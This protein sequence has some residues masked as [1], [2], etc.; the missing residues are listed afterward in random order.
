MAG[1]V[2]GINL[3]IRSRDQTDSIY[4]ND[5]VETDVTVREYLKG[6]AYDLINCKGMR[7]P[8]LSS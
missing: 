8:Y 5:V 1:N 6:G 2:K 3:R 7:A 4:I